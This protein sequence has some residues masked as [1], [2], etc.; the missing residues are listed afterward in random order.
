MRKESWQ[1]RG[2]GGKERRRRRRRR[3]RRR[4]RRRRSE[5]KKANLRLPP[6]SLPFSTKF[7]TNINLITSEEEEEASSVSFSSPPFRSF[8]PR[9]L[10]QGA[11]VIAFDLREEILPVEL[12]RLERHH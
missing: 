4:R 12:H 7:Q 10:E 6:S 8:V 1:A 11:Q 3:T 5:D 2:E 9:L